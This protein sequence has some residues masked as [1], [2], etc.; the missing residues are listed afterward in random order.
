MIPK[1]VDMS[2]EIGII[3]NVVADAVRLRGAGG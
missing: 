3:A 2:G 1:P